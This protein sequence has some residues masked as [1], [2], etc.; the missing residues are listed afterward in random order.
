MLNKVSRTIEL[1][2]PEDNLE[3]IYDNLDLKQQEEFQV[4][5]YESAKKGKV[6]KNSEN[7]PQDSNLL[8]TLRELDS[9]TGGSQRNALLH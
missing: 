5:L 7:I 4:A 6:L 2:F 9:K 3:A 1:I 8:Q